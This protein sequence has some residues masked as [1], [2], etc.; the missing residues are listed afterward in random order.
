VTDANDP[1]PQ[2][3]RNDAAAG[4]GDL[5]TGNIARVKALFP[6]IMTDGKVDFDVL[7]E[8]L[9]DAVETAEERYGL[10]WK[11]K[12]RARAF[13]LTPSLGTLR[14]A[15]EDSV[16]WETTKN[17]F[18]EADNLEALK[19]L[20]RSYANKINLIYIDP[21][22]N[23]GND[24][25]YKDDYRNSIA[26]YHRETGQIGED[27]ETLVS[28][29]ESGGRFHSDW[30]TMMYPRILLA[31]EFLRDDGF[32]FV[33]ADQNEVAHLRYIL[34]ETFGF[35]NRAAEITIINNLKGRNDRANIA[36]THEFLIA[37]SKSSDNR[38]NGLPLTEEQKAEFKYV[39]GRGEKYALRDLRKRGGPDRRED[40]PNMWFPIY[41]NPAERRAT[42]ERVSDNDVK[43][44]PLLS[45]GSDGYWRWGKERVQ[46]YLQYLE[47]K[48][49][50]GGK[51]NVNYR[52]Y[53][54]P[55]AG[56]MDDGDP[57]DPE[58]DD[59]ERTSK[60]KSSWS[61]PE[62]ST[63]V[64]RRSLKEL[65]PDGGFSFPKSVELMKRI[66]QLGSSDGQTVMD[67]F[68]GSGTL[69]QAIM[70]LSALQDGTRN[71]I[72]VQLP[73]MLKAENKDEKA[74]IKFLDKAKRP[75]NIAELT[76]ERLRRAGNKVRKE[77]PEADVDTGFRVY[78]LATSNLK[79]WQPDAE[80]LEASILDAVDNVMP[81]RTADDLLVE[82]LLKTGI[83][84]TLS[85][86]KRGIAGQTV[87]ALGGGT[88]MVCLGNVGAEDAEALGQGIADWV[89]E[90]D[91]VQTTVYFK[92]TGLGTNGNR[93]ATKANLAAILRQRLGDRIAKIASI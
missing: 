2:I 25:V 73:E 32:I 82:L 87:H 31:K 34:D 5:V 72:L 28:D 92:D 44:T 4:S 45:D 48:Q 15:P 81:G 70:E 11:G 18:I 60:P 40:R 68:A 76:K 89:S 55:S 23:T 83:D 67:F 16:D 53:L 43:I 7:R 42:L 12:R 49:T 64:A 33:S 69:G 77:Y 39:D 14:P 8:L 54:N 13:A 26:G 19:L 85:E 21:P 3:T 75:R 36:I 30:L 52:I 35:E 61:G 17:L 90:L 24:L 47:A 41:W 46:S 57:S 37:Y 1:I 50:P 65:M 78:K 84:L 71:Y 58:D 56:E 88:L 86:E 62:L 80:D 93:A 9:G 59:I 74:A 29:L 38:M 91:P 6:E 66:I 10:N 63:D 79:P 20:R 27:E 22:Y 51:W